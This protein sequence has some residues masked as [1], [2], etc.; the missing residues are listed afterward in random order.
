MTPTYLIEETTP[1]GKFCSH[2]MMGDNRHKQ[3][4]DILYVSFLVY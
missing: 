3:K 1:T 2:L 4:L